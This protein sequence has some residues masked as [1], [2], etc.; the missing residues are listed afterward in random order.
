[1]DQFE[2]LKIG[3]DVL[4]WLELIDQLAHFRSTVKVKFIPILHKNTNPIFLDYID[5][6][7]FG[8][9]YEHIQ[10]HIALFKKIQLE[11]KMISLLKNEGVDIL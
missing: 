2:N 6:K 1:M 7:H 4:M 8:T 5:F 9:T 10:F 3:V 11:F